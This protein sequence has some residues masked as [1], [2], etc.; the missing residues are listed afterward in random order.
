MKVSTRL[1]VAITIA[2]PSSQYPIHIKNRNV[3]RRHEMGEDM[4]RQEM[5]DYCI[6]MYE[7]GI[8]NTY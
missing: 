6:G 7:C 8:N 2:L 4:G 3:D 5:T 1:Q